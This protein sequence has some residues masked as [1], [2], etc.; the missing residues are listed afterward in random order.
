MTRVRYDREEPRL[1][2]EGHALAGPRG[3]DPVC[4]ALSML[5]MTI[6]RRM[7]ERAERMLP[8]V[9]RA[10]GRF[11]I[12]CRPE[13]GFEEACRESFDTVYAG[14]A[15]LAEERPD[16]VYICPGEGQAGEESLP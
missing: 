10:P 8:A 4:A 2:L 16:C 11:R 13:S 1:E 15:L 5:S 3:G 7:M 6:E 9:S 12:T 14:L